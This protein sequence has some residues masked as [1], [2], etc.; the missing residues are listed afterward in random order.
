[1]HC[2]AALISLFGVKSAHYQRYLFSVKDAVE[3]GFLEFVHRNRRRDV[4]AEHH[5]EICSDQLIRH[6]TLSSPA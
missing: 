5:V 4:V 3:S 1:M 2:S 6:S